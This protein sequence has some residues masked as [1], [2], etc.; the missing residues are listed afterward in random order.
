MTSTVRASGNLVRE[1]DWVKYRNRGLT[2]TKLVL[3]IRPDEVLVLGDHEN[4]PETRTLDPDHTE[5]TEVL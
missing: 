2:Q 1:G 5:I 3:T 4:D